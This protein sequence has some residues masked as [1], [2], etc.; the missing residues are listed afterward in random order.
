ME[1]AIRAAVENN[2]RW[3]DLV[4]RSHGIATSWQEGFWVSRRPSPRFYP[5]GITLQESIAAEEVIEELPS[6]ICSVKDS[7]ADLD[8]ARHGFALLFDAR[9]IYRPP[10]AGRAPP[11]GWATVSTEKDFARWLGACGLADVLPTALLHEESARFLKR[12]RAQDVQAG[13]VLN[14]S[15]SVVGLTI[16][17]ARACRSV[18][19]GATLRR[20]ADSNSLPSPSSG[21]SAARISKPRSTPGST[22]SP[23]SGFGS[24]YIDCGARGFDALRS[25]ASTRRAHLTQSV[26]R[27][28]SHAPR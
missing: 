19:F 2:A 4:C 7:F 22:T 5:E 12:E 28:E 14:R 23:R 16:C 17:S 26:S 8:L 10:T 24:K 9:W 18:R 27:S 1:D 6:G 15:G 13:A 21:T 25:A 11:T 3:C 20:S